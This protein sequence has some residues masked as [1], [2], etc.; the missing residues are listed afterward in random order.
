MNWIAQAGNSEKCLANP[1]GGG[2]LSQPLENLL[3]D[4]SAGDESQQIVR[5][6][7]TL[8]LSIQEFNPDRRIY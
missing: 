2:F 5:R 8:Q 7:A 6:E 3:H 1:I 4:G